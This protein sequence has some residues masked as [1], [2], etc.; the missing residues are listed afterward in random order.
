MYL[1]QINIIFHCIFFQDLRGLRAPHDIEK[2]Q[3]QAQTMLN[4]YCQTHLP[5]SDQAR[6]GK[7]LLTLPSLRSVNSKT[8]EKLF[9]RGANETIS[10]ERMLC[11]M[12]KAC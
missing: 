9:F 12:F 3:D 2:L 8:V 10:M 6:F 1:F 11:D 7:L 5:N 4:E